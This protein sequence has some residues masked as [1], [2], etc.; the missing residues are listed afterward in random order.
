MQILFIVFGKYCDDYTTSNIIEGLIDNSIPFNIGFYDESNNHNFTHQN[1]LISFS[2]ITNITYNFK[3]ILIT[4]YKPYFPPTPYSLENSPMKILDEWNVYHKTAY[5]DAT[6]NRYDHKAFWETNEVLPNVLR[7][8]PFNFIYMKKMCKWYFKR[9]CYIQDVD[10]GYIP[11]PYSFSR[12]KGRIKEL[13]DQEIK[14]FKNIDIFCSF[15]QNFTGMRK[16]CINISNILKNIDYIIDLNCNLNRE[17]YLKTVLA[18]YITLDAWGAG[19]LTTRLF[20]VALNYT[21]VFRQ[22]LDIVIPNDFDNT[23]IVEFENR[24]DLLEKLVIYLKN[25]NHLIEMSKNA[26]EHVFK[27]HTCQKRVEYMMN[28]LNSI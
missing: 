8:E 3:F 27:Y 28:I 11:F 1:L 21:V 5:I 15:P 9:E 4:T 16:D 22:K 19:Q 23:M 26:R 24:R 12:N 18:S 20:E 17:E 6:E 13:T 10:D 25:K 2:N 14:S 7:N